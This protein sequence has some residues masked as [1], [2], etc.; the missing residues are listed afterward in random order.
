[1]NRI[2]LNEQEESIQ[3]FFLSLPDDPE[4]TIVE[5]DG[6]ALA[7]IVLI[8][9][10]KRTAIGGTWTKAKNSRRCFLIDREIDGTLTP[11]EALELEQ[12]Q[13]RVTEHIDRVAPLP[14]EATR[15]LYEELQAKADA[16]KKR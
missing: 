7:R 9:L 5:L 11:D 14:L 6:R 12:L 2:N 3:R 1:M 4:G 8:P 16:A 13:R 10:R 15:K